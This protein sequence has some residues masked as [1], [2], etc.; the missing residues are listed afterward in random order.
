MIVNTNVIS[1]GNNYYVIYRPEICHSSIKILLPGSIH[2]GEKQ[3]TVS[4]RTTAR[5]EIACPRHGTKIE[6]HQRNAY[7]DANMRSLS[8]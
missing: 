8:E 2:R 4:S 7:I 3:V 1:G 6:E 5:E